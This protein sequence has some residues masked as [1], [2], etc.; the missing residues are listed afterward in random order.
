MRVRKANILDLQWCV[1][2]GIKFLKFYFPN[3]EVDEG[4]IHT[5][6]HALISNGVMIVT[7]NE[8]EVT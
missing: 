4:F 7:E 8:E 3:K 5:Q 2:E 6:L 1:S